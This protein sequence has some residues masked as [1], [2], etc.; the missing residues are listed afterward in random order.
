MSLSACH[1]I[2]LPIFFGDGTSTQSIPSDDASN[3]HSSLLAKSGLLSSIL[4]DSTFRLGETVLAAR[5]GGTDESEHWLNYYSGC[6]CLSHNP[7]NPTSPVLTLSLN[8]RFYKSDVF[9]L[10]VCLYW[11]SFI[12]SNASACE[13]SSDVFE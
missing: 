7:C 3:E 5:S 9:L 8:V 6:S 11:T 4:H 1:L 2:L 13:S 10:D 12:K